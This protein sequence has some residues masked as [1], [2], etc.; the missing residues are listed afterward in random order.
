LLF[1]LEEQ[2]ALLHAAVFAKEAG[3]PFGDALSNATDK[4]K[5][6]S[7]PNQENHLNRH[8]AGF[9]VLSRAVKPSIQPILVELEHAVASECSVEIEY[10]TGREEQSKRRVVD[11]YGVLYWNNKWYVIAFCHLRNA[12]RS[13]RVERITA[14]ERT[15]SV[16]K[17]PEA[18]SAREFFMKNLLPDLEGSEG[19]VSVI[20]EGRSEALDDL[21]LHWF[22]GHHL[23]KRTSNQAVFIL[24]DKMVQAYVPYFLLSYG[25]SIQILEPPI[26]KKR[27]VEIASELMAHYQ[28]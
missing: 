19:L 24:E 23:E 22:L 25:K 16:F 2:T 10:H 13:F 17:R 20:I 9:E 12:I 3:Y 6:Y 14:I 26:L 7:N 28:L 4:L 8:L 11:P 15:E 5:M 18:F 27:L 21:C 1:D